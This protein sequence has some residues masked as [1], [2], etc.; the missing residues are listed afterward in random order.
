M[1][2]GMVRYEG[3]KM[4]KSL[5]NL[6]MV[7]DVLKRNSADA[8]RLY[9]LGFRY[10][11]SWTYQDES[12]QL[13][14]NLAGQLRDAAQLPA[15]GANLGPQGGQELDANAWRER[16]LAALDNDLNTPDAISVL[17]GLATAIHEVQAR[18]GNVEAAQAT[19]REL[20]GILGLTLS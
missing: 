15:P 8:L 3:E 20:T 14:E 10:R 18:G 17:H 13:A 1:H 12:L 4:S 16:F 6:V 19:L 11:D 2:T 5:G 7:R 9:L